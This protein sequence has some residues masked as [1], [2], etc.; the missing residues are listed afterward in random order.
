MATIMKRKLQRTNQHCYTARIRVKGYREEIKSFSTRSAAKAW[1]TST[2]A[3]MREGRYLITH[4]K[5]NITI[6]MMIS[7]YLKE[8][9]PK[10]PKARLKGTVSQQLRFW[11]RRIGHFKLTEISSR[12]IVQIRDELSVGITPRGNIRKPATVNSYINCLNHCFNIAMKEWNWINQ[13]PVTNVGRLKKN[14][15]RVRFLKA[16]ERE[17][18]LKACEQVSSGYLKKIVQFAI[19][20]GSR[21]GE[22]ENL[23]W[24]QIDF[25]RRKLYFLDTKNGESRGVHISEPLSKLLKSIHS[26]D[27]HSDHLV[28]RSPKDP[29]RPIR[30]NNSFKKALKM[31]RIKDFRFHD[32]RHDAAS[33]LAQNG[34]T[35]LEIA[36]VLGH[37]TLAMVKRYSHLTEDHT[38][39]ILEKM[40]SNI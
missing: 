1:A 40:N 19:Y 29:Y 6:E 36:S 35:L 11:Q 17:R 25:R 3:A 30:F 8:V 32:L 23:R 5:Q 2:E 13:N 22:L 15:A 33:L 28:F 38:K 21:R 27:C 14:N 18:L 16:H 34:A 9:L 12:L 39:T 31:A 7:K 37:K 10:N 20:T 24:G 4:T 26:A